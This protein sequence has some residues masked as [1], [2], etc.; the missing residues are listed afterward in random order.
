MKL[1]SWLKQSAK[2]QLFFT[3]SSSELTEDGFVVKLNEKLKVNGVPASVEKQNIQWDINNTDSEN[4]IVKVYDGALK[5]KL[6]QPDVEPQSLQPAGGVAVSAGGSTKNAPQALS[7]EEIVN[8]LSCLVQFNHVGKFSFVE[9]RT[10]ITPPN[11]PEVPGH[12]V[13]LNES[14][15]RWASTLTFWGIAGLVAAWF[16]YNPRAM[17]GMQPAI[18]VGALGCVALFISSLLNSKYQQGVEHNRK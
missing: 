1:W 10:F 4:Y 5:Q 15:L 16:L 11:L 18:V 9:S 8:P 14:A 17:R 2:R 12:P 3:D 6:V 13:P 7:S